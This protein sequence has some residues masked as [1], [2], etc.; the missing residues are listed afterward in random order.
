MSHELWRQGSKCGPENNI[1]FQEQ[2]YA[3]NH[4]ESLVCRLVECALQICIHLLQ[5]CP[6]SAYQWIEIGIEELERA[7]AAHG[8]NSTE[9]HMI[10]SSISPILS[11][12]K[13]MVELGARALKM[14]QP[15][16]PPRSDGD[17]CVIAY[18]NLHKQGASTG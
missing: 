17:M 10:W 6:Y 14:Q 11:R 3:I 5:N 12:F 15:I 1:G 7:R 18:Q 13:G 2:K 8:T 4:E 9:Q 16:P